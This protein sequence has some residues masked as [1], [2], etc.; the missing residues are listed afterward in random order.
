MRMVIDALLISLPT[1]A[2]V[3]ILFV[4]AGISLIAL[5]AVGQMLGE[6][7]VRRL[8]DGVS[9]VDCPTCLQTFGST[10]VSTMRFTHYMWDPIPGQPQGPGNLPQTTVQITC[11]HCA[12]EH[13]FDFDGTLFTG[14]PDGYAGVEIRMK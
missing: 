14:P 2:L 4:A 8:L 3:L 7:R 9:K 5:C 13:Q 12:R 10:I 1:W 11:P 6:R